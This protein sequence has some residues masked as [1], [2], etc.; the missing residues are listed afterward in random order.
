[1]KVSWRLSQQRPR[2]CLLQQR[3]WWYT[4]QSSQLRL[5][6]PLLPGKR[7]KLMSL[8][9]LAQQPRS[10]TLW[11]V[12]RQRHIAACTAW[13]V[14]MRSAVGLRAVLSCMHILTVDLV[15]LIR[16]LHAQ[17]SL[18]A[19]SGSLCMLPPASL[20]CCCLPD[21]HKYS[22]LQAYH[23]IRTLSTVI[24]AAALK[25]G[26]LRLANMLKRDPK[27]QQQ[28]QVQADTSSPAAALDS[29]QPEQQHSSEV[30]ARL[31]ATAAGYVL[32]WGHTSCCAVI[33]AVL[34]QCVG[35]SP[36]TR[37]SV[38]VTATAGS[39]CFHSLHKLRM[40]MLC[41]ALQGHD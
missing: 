38:A 14:Y 13:H 41:C 31:K 21:L 40:H 16:K 15:Q 26:S 27:Q 8:Q 33:G 7:M 36:D 37:V 32:S 3:T 17:C 30:V 1:M 12:C 34:L 19:A 18:P 4:A 9:H 29:P 6:M 2:R 25:L 20:A 22:L 5:L 39:I 35:L 28:Q 24:A 11:K 23:N 10:L